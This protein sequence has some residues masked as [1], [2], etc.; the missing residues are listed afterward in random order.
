MIRLI[1]PLIV[2]SGLFW[3]VRYWLRSAPEGVQKQSRRFIY[4]ILISVAFG[5]AVL[6]VITLLFFIGALING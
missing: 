6:A 3:V 1:I 2:L 5:V 4:E